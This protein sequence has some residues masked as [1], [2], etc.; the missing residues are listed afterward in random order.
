MS[1]TEL[2]N[3]HPVLNDVCFVWIGQM[4]AT[5]GTPN[6]KTGELSLYGD[7]IAFSG[8]TA[9]QDR[10]QFVENY[11]DYSGR[12]ESIKCNIHTGRKFMRGSSVRDYIEHLALI[13]SNCSH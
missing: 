6:I 11:Y 2:A 1:I 3:D 9:K 10:D 8:S 7:F 4:N 5:T 12:A 13:A